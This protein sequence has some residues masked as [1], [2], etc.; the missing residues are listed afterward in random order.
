[1]ENF[2]LASTLPVLFGA[3]VLLIFSLVILRRIFVNVGAREIAIKERT[4]SRRED[5]AG[6]RRRN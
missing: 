2:D 6:T 3:F 5:A 1:M 4:I